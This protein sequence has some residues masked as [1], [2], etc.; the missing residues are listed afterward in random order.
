MWKHLQVAWLPAVP[1]QI[2]SIKSLFLALFRKVYLAI[3][4]S[5]RHSYWLRESLGCSR[6]WDAEEGRTLGFWQA[7]GGSYRHLHPGFCTT[8]TKHRFFPKVTIF[9][10]PS[11]PQTSIRWVSQ[12]LKW[13]TMGLV[14][15]KYFIF[16]RLACWFKHLG[17]LTCLQLRLISLKVDS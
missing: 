8:Q 11:L 3:Y 4:R 10:V 15:T 16:T 6:I 17:N 9:Q 2:K 12:F 5:R 7:R 13:G 14:L 1:M